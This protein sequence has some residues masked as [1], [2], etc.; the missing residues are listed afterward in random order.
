MKQTITKGK[1]KIKI[2]NESIEKRLYIFD[3]IPCS[4]VS[5]RG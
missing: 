5:V 1:N 3:F 2:E 4:F